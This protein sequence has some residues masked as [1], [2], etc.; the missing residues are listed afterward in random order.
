LTLNVAAQILA[1]GKP[2]I[3]WPG[4]QPVDAEAVFGGL[5]V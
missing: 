5:E 1:A 3:E 4:W 2:A